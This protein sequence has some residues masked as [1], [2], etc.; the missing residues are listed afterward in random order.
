[1]LENKN[2]NEQNK[3]IPS[4]CNG[5][6]SRL[7]QNLHWEAIVVSPDPF[8]VPHNCPMQTQDQF[9]ITS[10]LH[11]LSDF[12]VSR[13]ASTVWTRHH[14]TSRPFYPG[15]AKVQEIE[16]ILSQLR[17]RECVII[18]KMANPWYKP[19]TLFGFWANSGGGA[20]FQLQALKKEEEKVYLTDALADEGSVQQAPL[21]IVCIS[22]QHT[23][24]ALRKE[25]PDIAHI[26]DTI[27]LQSQFENYVEGAG[28]DFLV[29][30]NINGKKQQLAKVHTRCKSMA[31]SVE[32]VVDISKCDAVNPGIEFDCEARDKK[33]Q[34]SPIKIGQTA[35]FYSS[36]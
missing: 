5:C 25:S 32:W 7:C 8:A 29:Y 35:A 36:Y 2:I 33:S 18:A 11:R 12:D 23:D 28:V 21:K 10:A 16:Q 19:W 27:V 20:D 24:S 30:G 13:I 31:S 6:T 4:V 14:Y 3:R 1:M 22:W 15:H 17:R 26:G 9:I 34:R